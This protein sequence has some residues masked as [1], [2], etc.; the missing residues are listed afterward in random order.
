MQER[1]LFFPPCTALASRHLRDPDLPR[2]TTSPP[3]LLPR[4]LHRKGKKR[5]RAFSSRANPAA[6]Q[7]EESDAPA[8][9][10]SFA[11]STAFE[12]PFM[13]AEL[14]RV[15]QNAK[16]KSAPVAERQHSRLLDFATSTCLPAPSL[17]NLASNLSLPS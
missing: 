6:A 1:K 4:P 17:L 10:P 11:L 3:P 5:G 16:R 13:A 15:I 8:P 9:A 7:N 14:V 12:A 2:H